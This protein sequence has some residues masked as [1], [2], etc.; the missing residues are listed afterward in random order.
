MSRRCGWQV[1]AAVLLLGALVLPQGCS[2]NY[3]APYRYIGSSSEEP[4]DRN[5]P[6]APVYEEAL[7]VDSDSSGVSISLSSPGETPLASYPS[8]TTIVTETVPRRSSS[9]AQALEGK[10]EP[11]VAVAIFFLIRNIYFRTVTMAVAPIVEDKILDGV[12]WLF[13]KSSP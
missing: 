10:I 1:S 12:D 13:A 9:V 11:V 3:Q 7:A 8:E 2:T 5:E 6:D 4:R